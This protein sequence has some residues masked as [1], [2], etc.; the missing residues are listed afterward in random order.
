MGIVGLYTSFI[1]ANELNAPKALA[2]I[3]EQTLMKKK[4]FGE[5]RHLEVL[6]LL[7]KIKS[8]HLDL[9]D[10]QSLNDT[11]DTFPY[12][13]PHLTVSYDHS[14][15]NHFCL[16]PTPS[17]FWKAFNKK[18]ELA[19][20]HLASLT[21]YPVYKTSGI[22]SNYIFKDLYFQFRGHVDRNFKSSRIDLLF[23]WTL[24]DGD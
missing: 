13:I 14:W 21:N 2:S 1:M 19:S 10:L 6:L 17:L 4:T 23:A 9:R 20:D 7:K 11:L 18:P 15:D 22:N 24:Y 16:S 12:P 5:L 3:E 8:D